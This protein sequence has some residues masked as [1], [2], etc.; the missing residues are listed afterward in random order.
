MNF[1]QVIEILD[2]AIGGP[3]ADIGAHGPFW[4]GITR[5]KFVAKKVFSKD[6]VVLGDGAASNLVRALKGETPFG[7]GAIFPRMP[8]GGLPAAPAESIALIEQWINDGC[9]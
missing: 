5:D 4:R 9:P 8:A 3:E 2:Q 7:E 6:L 1:Q